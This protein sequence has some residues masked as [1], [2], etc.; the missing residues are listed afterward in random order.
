MILGILGGL[1]PMATAA[2]YQLI[3]EL[4]D[5]RC[6]QEHIKTIIYSIPDTPPRVDY[7]VGKSKDNPGI[8]LKE[9]AKKLEE[10]GANIVVM[11]CVTAH[12][13]KNQIIEGLSIPFIDMIDETVEVLK[14]L[15]IKK[16]GI[17]GTSGTI[18]GG[19]LQKKLLISGIDSVLPDEKTQCCIDN[20]IFE[21]LKKNIF[22]D[23]REISLLTDNLFSKGAEFNL[24]ACT[25]LS[26]LNT[27]QG[28]G[29]KYIDMMEILAKAS[30]VR[31]EKKCI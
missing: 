11:P 7:I 10:C 26:L 17:V 19:H 20:L 1:G 5:A 30:I 18:I 25:E 22:I 29:D 8:F 2:F 3:V 16:V 6:D 27:K 15:K 9:G 21:R 4:T 12:Y 23:S 24:I 14:K 28:F 31:C 13:F